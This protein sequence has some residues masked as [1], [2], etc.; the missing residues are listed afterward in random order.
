MPTL[1]L[2]F[3][4]VLENPS[5]PPYDPVTGERRRGPLF[6]RW[7]PTGPD[8]G[9][10]LPVDEPGF[11]LRVWFEPHGYEKDGRIVFDYER[12]EINS[13]SIAAAAVLDAGPLLG[14]VRAADV[15]E[16]CLQALQDGQI[17]HPVCALF[18]RKVA[19]AL[20]RPLSRVIETLR[21]NFGQYWINP[22]VEWNPRE[23]SLARHFRQVI[24]T[25]WSLDDGTT[26]A[27]F[28][29]EQLPSVDETPTAPED[30][31]A[32]LTATDWR[33]LEQS[34]REGYEPHFGASLISRCHQAVTAGDY[35]G[36]IILARDAIEVC[37]NEFIQRKTRLNKSLTERL[38]AFHALP[39]PARLAVVG[40]LT[41]AFSPQ[42]LESIHKFLEI[43]RKLVREGWIPPANVGAEVARV[44]RLICALLPGPKFKFPRPTLAGVEEIPSEAS[45][46]GETPAQAADQRERNG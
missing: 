30:F 29:P 32:L 1:L 36:A 14:L 43:H 7:L 23:N 13:A 40:T 25:Q 38:D 39:L 35:P 27:D 44:L 33:T 31:D 26:W 5:V 8:D 16:E 17:N 10:E 2:R 21:T 37:L 15:E 24:Q 12:Q 42:D 9:I 18:A 11:D 4:I 41:E 46:D 34:L 28:A 20:H 45:P 22:L 3:A 6:H 19:A